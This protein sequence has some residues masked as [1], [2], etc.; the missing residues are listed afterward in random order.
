MKPSS[1]APSCSLLHPRRSRVR[2]LGS[3]RDA[4]ASIGGIASARHLQPPPA[5]PACHK[6]VSLGH[7][8]G[9]ATAFP[10]VSTPS[11]SVESAPSDTE[12]ED[13]AVDLALAHPCM[14]SA[15]FKQRPQSANSLPTIDEASTGQKVNAQ[16]L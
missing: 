6:T 16:T 13:E 12:E 1:P 10:L 5:R 3:R 9:R 11:V 8:E 4:V 7:A 15:S 14:R 2:S